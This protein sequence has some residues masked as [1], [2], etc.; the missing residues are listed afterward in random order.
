[1][2]KSEDKLTSIGLWARK[3]RHRVIPVVNI[4]AF[5]VFG[6]SL[7][8][9]TKAATPFSSIE[10]E[11]GSL[12][13]SARIVSVNGASE[14]Q[15]VRF[16]PMSMSNDLGIFLRNTTLG[17][18]HREFENAS[19]QEVEQNLDNRGI[20]EPGTAND[21]GSGG[22][23]GQFRFYCQYSHFNY[24]DPIVKFNQPGAAHLHMY[25]G[26]TSVN[27]S[28]NKDSLVNK[29]GGTCPGFEANRTGYWMPAVLDGSNKAVIPNQILMYYKSIPG[30]AAVTKKMPQGLQMIAGNANGNTDTRHHHENGIIWACYDGSSSYTYK[31]QTI[32]D[33]CPPGANISLWALIYFP[34]C[35]KVDGA[36]N[37]ILSSAQL[38]ADGSQG[39]RF[40]DHTSYMVSQGGVNKCPASHPYTMPR[41]SYH[42][43]WPGNLNYS[44]WK[45][46]SDAMAGVA[47]GFSLHADWYG[48]WSDA[49]QDQWIKGC[50]NMS[51]NC[52]NGVMTAANGQP[53]RML[54]RVFNNSGS[55]FYS[56]PNN[57][58]VPAR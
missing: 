37:P 44:Q 45:L 46:S 29:G 36:G 32:P 56:A 48:G 27:A 41:V 50:I 6:I 7:L 35:L 49:V 55:Q 47:D 40:Y 17:A 10:P 33:S 31:G 38:P 21:N 51:R 11:K 9:F 57:L 1:M 53:G 2:K 5:V 12:R 20:F 26:N 13:G 43:A 15:A 39:A 19:M 24:D 4:L 58:T 18:R 14:G 54:K 23:E 8:V 52:S 3:Y 34:S 42:I 28:T 16:S 22:P 30:Q 25:W